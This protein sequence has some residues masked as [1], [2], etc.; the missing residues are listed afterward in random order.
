MSAS[1]AKV[2]FYRGPSFETRT[3]SIQTIGVHF[4]LQPS[5]TTE[6]RKRA[7]TTIVWG[8]RMEK[9]VL[10][11]EMVILGE[12]VPEDS[13]DVS[14]GTFNIHLSPLRGAN[15]NFQPFTHLVSALSSQFF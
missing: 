11:T 13:L 3:V 12:L 1:P 15:A 14:L 7:R 10:E 9:R 2:A 8:A 6:L 4:P 5:N